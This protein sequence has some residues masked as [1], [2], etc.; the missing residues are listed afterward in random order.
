MVGPGLSCGGSGRRTA[1]K[2]QV[3]ELVGGLSGEAEE[4]GPRMND[5]PWQGLAV[6]PTGWPKQDFT[7]SGSHS[8]T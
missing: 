7:K 3:A 5:G 4:H 8:F 1:R 2:A 6:R